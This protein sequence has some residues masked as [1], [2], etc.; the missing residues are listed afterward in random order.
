MLTWT[1]Y[2]TWLP[3][4]ERGFV[5]NVVE[6][7]LGNPP[8]G[9]GG[10]KAAS[11]NVVPTVQAK[12]IRAADTS[13]VNDEAPPAKAIRA[14]DA[15]GLN[16]EAPPAKTIRAADASGVNNEAPPAK[17]IRAADASGLNDE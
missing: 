4:D 12:A 14:A 11:P 3:G 6:S 9:V 16:D 8:T 17:T 15:S 7:V 13:G 2:G 5:G 1:T 10:S